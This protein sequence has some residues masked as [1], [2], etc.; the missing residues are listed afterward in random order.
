MQIANLLPKP[1]LKTL[2]CLSAAVVG[3]GIVEPPPVYAQFNPI[4]A[5]IGGALLGAQRGMRGGGGS[6][7]SRPSRRGSDDSSSSSDS[8]T[9]TSTSTSSQ[10]DRDRTL[11]SLAPPSQKQT[12]V[13]KSIS[14]SAA[15]GEVGSTSDLSQVGQAFLSEGDRD[16][17]AWIRKILALLAT[18]QSRLKDNKG[19]SDVTTHSV[20]QSLDQ[21]FKNTNLTLFESFLGENWS[22]ERVRVLILDRVNVELGRSFDG[23]NRG[24]LPMEE[25]DRLI[26][27]SAEAVYHRLFEI[28]E[29]LAANRSSAL[30]LQR[31]YQTHGGLVD[32][33]L[34]EVADRMLTKASTAATAKFEA[35]MRRDPDGF[36][37]R[38]RA[39]RVVLDC[40][41]QNVE[42]ITS[43]ETGIAT[44]EEIEQ[45]INQTASTDCS[46]W[47]DAQFGTDKDKLA[48]QKPMPLRA[49][50]SAT[51]PR[52]D[53]SMYG[54]ATSTF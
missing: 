13:L 40:L 26:Q 34:R 20:E 31:L 7:V 14:A 41:S 49:V 29:L 44:I 46:Q 1:K 39:Q 52:D 28:S 6:R 50:W 42:K 33:Q 43:S 3:L 23:P 2:F 47:L 9:S 38:Y 21:A 18:A 36:A 4:G 16:Y 48:P 11:A 54:R 53:P 45:K 51:G 12:A 15:V 27:K 30:F 22:S 25:M 35:A 5:M 19:S 37:L 24:T 32:D 10:S 17:T 8:S